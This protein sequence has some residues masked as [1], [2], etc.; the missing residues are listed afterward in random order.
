MGSECKSSFIAIPEREL[1]DGI[2]E[3][4]DLTKKICDELRRVC[5]NVG[6]HVLGCGN[7]LTFAFLCVAGVKMADGLEW[8]RTFAAE[9]FHLHHFQHEPV[10]ESASGKF[11]SSTAEFL[12]SQDVEYP[13]RAATKNLM[14]LQ[15]FTSDLAARLPSKTVNQ[16]I[17]QSFGSKAG[18]A[19]REVEL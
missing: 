9:N 6:L 17:F 13:V 4:F 5:P 2:L 10:I 1:G 18:T 12:L 7:P 8:Y 14:S 15:A 16:L 3:R 19:L 11:Q